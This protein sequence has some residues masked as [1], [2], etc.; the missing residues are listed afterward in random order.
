MIW[1]CYDVNWTASFIGEWR[2]RPM[3][4]LE[5]IFPELAIDAALARR[6]LVAILREEVTK[7]GFTRALFGLSGGIDSALT[8]YLGAEALGPDHVKAVLM[9]YRSSSPESLADARLVV[10]ALGID[11]RVVDITP[12]IDAYFSRRDIPASDEKTMKLRRGNKMARERMTILYDLSMTENALVLGT[13][14]KTELLLGYGTLFGDMASAINPLGDLY[15]SQVWQLAAAV[16]VPERIVEKPPTADLWTGQ[17]D[18]EEIGYSYAEIDRIFYYLVDRRL[19]ADQVIE[20]GFER[21]FVEH[22]ARLLRQSQYKRRLPVVAKLGR[23]TIDR[24]FR[25][26]RDWGY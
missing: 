8:A 10:E 14:N 6:M 19:S 1:I 26:P 24:D 16:G 5:E 21:A 13:S 15:K 9:P 7:V 18:Q 4:R 12:Q 22:I 3:P 11:S 25:Y 20:R 23:R 2:I 17:T